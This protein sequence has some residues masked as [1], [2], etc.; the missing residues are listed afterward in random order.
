MSDH[1]HNK[2][3]INYDIRGRYYYIMTIKDCDGKPFTNRQFSNEVF[4]ELMKSPYVVRLTG[5]SFYFKAIEISIT[6]GFIKSN[7]RKFFDNLK[8]VDDKLNELLVTINENI[9]EDTNKHDGCP[10]CGY[11]H[12]IEFTSYNYAFIDGERK[13]VSL[14]G[15]KKCNT[16]IYRLDG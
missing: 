2:I 7:E 12:F 11:D 14:M 1:V 8:K 16:I 5:A 13:R 6:A 15:C 9:L 4:K 3:D 10:H